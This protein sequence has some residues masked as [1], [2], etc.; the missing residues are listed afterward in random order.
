MRLERLNLVAYGHFTG[1]NLPLGNKSA[2]HVIVG[3]NEV[4]KSTTRRALIS[5]LF[6][7]PHEVEDGFLHDAKDIT[8]G[9]D[10]IAKDGRR[11]AY[12]RKRRGKA[13]L[14]LADGTPVDEAT[15]STFLG[16]ISKDLFTKVFGLDHRLLREH[17]RALIADGGALGYSLAEAAS[18]VSGLRGALE[19]IHAERAL[20]FLPSGRV[21]VMNQ[22]IFRLMELDRDTNRRAVTVTAYHRANSAVVEAEEAVNAALKR[23]QDN[24]AETRRLQ[25]IQRNLPRRAQHIELNRQRCTLGDVPN[26]PADADLKHLEA[27]TAITADQATVD[28]ESGL[29]EEIQ[30]RKGILK[31]DPEVL[32]QKS[33]IEGLKTIRSVSEDRL[34]DLPRRLTELQGYYDG[35]KAILDGADLSGD[36]ANLAKTIPS[37]LK[38]N[39]IRRLIGEGRTIT[40]RKEGAGEKLVETQAILTL[41][42]AALAQAI[43]P[44]D[45]AELKLALE[46]ATALGDISTEIDRRKRLLERAAGALKEVVTSLG[47]ANGDITKLRAVV[48][49]PVA[50]IA[51]YAEKLRK[52]EVSFDTASRDRDRIDQE[53]IS[54][55]QAIAALKGEAGFTSEEDLATARAQ[56][57][58]G[59]E[60][61]RGM[62]IDHRTDLS[63][64]VA[65]FT[66]RKP[67]AEVYGVQVGHA[68]RLADT[69]RN[70]AT[71]VA[72]FALSHL[73]EKELSGLRD[74]AAGRIATTSAQKTALLDEWQNLWTG[75]STPI[76][77]PNE[78]KEFVDRRDR[79]LAD[80]TAQID[81]QSAIE[82]LAAKRAAS[83]D[84]LSVALRATG[85]TVND[86]MTFE[87]LRRQTRITVERLAV[88]ANTFNRASQAAETARKAYEKDSTAIETT[89]IASQEWRAHWANA[90][91]DVSLPL[92]LTLDQAGE[93]L[94]AYNKLAIE[95][96]NIDNLDRR[97]DSMNSD[98]QAFRREIVALSE[99]TGEPNPVNPSATSQLLEERLSAAQA[100][101]TET[102]NLEGQIR[103]HEDARREAQAK[104]DN[105]QAIVAALCQQAGCT[106]DELA[107]VIGR[108]N[109][110][111][112]LDH[113]IGD[114]ETALLQDGDGKDLEAIVTECEGHAGDTVAA[115]LTAKEAEAIQAQTDLQQAM[116]IRAQ[117]KVDYEQLFG[118]NQAVDVAQSAALVEAELSGLV[119]QYVDLTIQEATL[120]KAIETYRER[121][122]GPLIGRAKTLF[123]EL[124]DGAYSGVRV[125]IGEGDEPI[126]IAEHSTGRSLEIHQLSDGTVDALYLALRFAVVE[127]HNATREPIP[128]IA[129]DLLV[130]L[131][132]RRA[133]AAF[134]TLARISQTSQ[135]LLFTHHDHMVHLAKKAIPAEM[136]QIHLLDAPGIRAVP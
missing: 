131:D 80:A 136:L 126:I 107:G 119:E 89:Q 24:V 87:E 95:K 35:A 125:D 111:K 26:L 99:L 81:E 132:D 15:V 69:M 57:D 72:A 122:E 90:L 49:P 92:D 103:I 113:R 123:K 83:T 75:L 17:A 21:P 20:L 64:Q 67:L 110:A 22:R 50:T 2:V 55:R 74:E 38:R 135:V 79:V 47:I 71:Q 68:D 108:S 25:R 36:P 96:G 28:R 91:T 52:I 134:R 70:H 42:E 76:H 54:T 117:R 93:V 58:K 31:L 5:V 97:I 3:A 84:E 12:I 46:N 62:Y 88:V 45:P 41:A 78:M 56:R 27:S 109:S 100:A 61:V 30:V 51:R 127:E 94:E 114:L 82:A 40:T 60:F 4:G 86:S 106:V 19:N 120:R 43:A 130:N 73:K 65:E 112:D 10:L 59:W 53:L 116:D 98:I 11:L 115:L 23:Q 18:G 104:V 63:D 118:E 102:I 37:E 77:L 7:Y 33:A 16:G 9:A 6:G 8:V 34:I 66:G 48:C 129:D 133:M 105:N 124:T 1:F 101:H 128:F 85:Q 14:A 121:N 29:L 39:T 44:T 13:A 32:A